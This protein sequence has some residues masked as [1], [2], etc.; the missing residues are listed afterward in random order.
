MLFTNP[1]H[2]STVHKTASQF[3]EFRRQIAGFKCAALHYELF[4]T[5][6][7]VFDAEIKFCWEHHLVTVRASII[8]KRLIAT[9]SPGSNHVTTLRFKNLHDNHFVLDVLCDMLCWVQHTYI[10][11]KLLIYVY[12]VMSSTLSFFCV[13]LFMLYKSYMNK[14]TINYKNLGIFNT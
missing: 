5:A 7:R 10:R 8:V 14:D 12:L 4:T 13:L 3:Y 9:F 6:W 2:S 11:T 1:T